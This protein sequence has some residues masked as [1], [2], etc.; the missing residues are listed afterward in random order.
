M[1]DTKSG[2]GLPVID[3][4]VDALLPQLLSVLVVVVVLS[5]AEHHQAFGLSLPDVVNVFQQLLRVGA[6][7]LKRHAKL[8]R[9][10]DGSFDLVLLL[11]NI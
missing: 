5:P 4:A 9:R 10:E 3:E 7:P 6:D 2:F 8:S 1:R 11:C